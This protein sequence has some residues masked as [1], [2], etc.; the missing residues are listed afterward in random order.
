M[1]WITKLFSVML[2]GL[3]FFGFLTTG[4]E[5]LFS[6]MTIVVTLSPVFALC[7]DLGYQSIEPELTDRAIVIWIIMACVSIIAVLL[8]FSLLVGALILISC[9]F[10]S[11]AI[12]LGLVFLGVRQNKQT[13]EL[14]LPMG[15]SF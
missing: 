7:Y 5:S 1:F 4:W 15:F 10:A 6:L 3:T 14:V 11:I 9:F 8:S 2:F 12:S 13:S